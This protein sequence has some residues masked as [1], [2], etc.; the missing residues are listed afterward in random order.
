MPQAERV[1][2]DLQ[3]FF[4]RNFTFYGRQLSMTF[5]NG[6]HIASN[7][8]GGPHCQFEYTAAREISKKY[9]PFAI[10]DPNANAPGC[11]LIGSARERMVATSEYAWLTEAEMKRYSPYL[12]QYP[13]G[14]DQELTSIGNMVCRNLAGK[15]ATFTTD[16]LISGNTRKF[17]V[18]SHYGF[19]EKDLDLSPLKAELAKCGEKIVAESSTGFRGG[20]GNENA[21]PRITRETENGI[22]SMRQAGVTDVICLCNIILSALVSSA[23]D[24]QSYRPE[25]ILSSVGGQDF[26]FY[27]KSFWTAAQRPSMLGITFYPGQVPYPV[28]TLNQA[29]ASVDPGFQIDGPWTRMMPMQAIYWQLLLIASGIQMAGPDL[30]P[31]SFHKAL[32]NT[33]FPNPIFPQ[34]E[35]RVGFEDKTHSMT[36]DAAMFWWSDVTPGPHS[37]TPAGAWCYVGNGRRFNPFDWPKDLP[38]FNG[39]CV[40]SPR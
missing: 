27:V 24:R 3:T 16:P 30:T 2:K 6:N 22:I 11:F 36:K 14:I 29:L 40:T 8:S 13:M 1:T 20:E 19:S 28:M 4:N 12:W 17:G 33:R 25:W 18:M 15:P 39:R 21:V 35:G 10:T 32:Q 23:A 34:Q 31:Q 37:D 7:T 9:A 38:L 26:N 5:L